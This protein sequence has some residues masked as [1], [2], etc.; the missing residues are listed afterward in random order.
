MSF[1]VE[2]QTAGLF[3]RT[4][5]DHVCSTFQVFTLI[6]HTSLLSSI[7]TNILP[8]PSLTAASGL[9][10]SGIVCITLS[11]LASITVAFDVT[12]VP[13]NYGLGKW[14]ID[15]CIGA[16]SCSLNFFNDAEIFGIEYCY[17]AVSAVADVSFIEFAV[18]MA[19]PCTPLTSVIVATLLPVFIST[20][21][22][23]LP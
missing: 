18:A 13:C 19:I 8:I 2:S 7:F 10:A 23:I 16:F 5:S 15:D 6:M 12:S 9:P 21:F 4:L 22:T 3:S 14:F 11:V 20:T 1:S 17:V